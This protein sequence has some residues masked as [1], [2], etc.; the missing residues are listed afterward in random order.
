MFS[1]L[2]LSTKPLVLCLKNASLLFLVRAM[3]PLNPFSPG[4][5]FGLTLRK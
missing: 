2:S 5:V 4:T 1:V 3:V